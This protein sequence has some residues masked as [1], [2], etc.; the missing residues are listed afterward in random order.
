MVIVLDYGVVVVVVVVVVLVV[1]TV[2]GDRVVVG[3]HK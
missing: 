1:V 2:Q 3:L